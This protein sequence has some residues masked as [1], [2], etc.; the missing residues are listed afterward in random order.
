MR[1]STATSSATGG[2]T[3]AT[4]RRARAQ[5]GA[6]VDRGLLR[7]GVPG[8][9]RRADGG[10]RAPQRRQVRGAG[11]AARG[12]A[13]ATPTPTPTATPAPAPARDAGARAGPGAAR[14]AVAVARLGRAAGLRRGRRRRRRRL[15]RRRGRRPAPR[16]PGE[17]A[18]PEGT[19][20]PTPAPA[21][22][23]APPP[24][25]IV[26]RAAASPNMFVPGTLLADRADRP[27]D[28]RAV[29]ARGQAHGRFA[30]VGHAWREAAWRTSGTWSDF[31]DWLRSR[32]LS[33]KVRGARPRSVRPEAEHAHPAHTVFSSRRRGG[34]LRRQ[35]HG[36]DA[37]DDHRNRTAQDR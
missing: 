24:K 11:A 19:P 1:A 22:T 30:G 29:G 35:H 26:T 15:R 2:S 27:A 18:I 13:T 16:A 23:P 6:A 37:A 36:A 8:L 34:T 10:D 4:T 28:R 17:D 25:L 21:A 33:R 3:T 31:T 7:G 32:T 14:A 5:A 20:S 12:R 9:P